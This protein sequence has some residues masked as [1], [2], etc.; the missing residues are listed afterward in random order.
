MSCKYK[1]SGLLQ[2][3]RKKKRTYRYKW[4]NESL[5]PNK[6]LEISLRWK[7]LQSRDYLNIT[8]FRNHVW[9]YFVVPK[10]ALQS[11]NM[12]SGVIKKMIEEWLNLQQ[13]KSLAYLNDLPSKIKPWTDWI[14]RTASS[15]FPYV[16]Y[17]SKNERSTGIKFE[18]ITRRYRKTTQAQTY[19]ESELQNTI[20]EHNHDM[21]HQKI[22]EKLEDLKK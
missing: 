4:T 10:H 22:Q 14:H 18:I 9:Q 5:H 13:M 15:S 8:I 7:A 12:N 19:S 2:T 20:K 6:V 21:H 3:W 11:A 1:Q 16:I 17:L